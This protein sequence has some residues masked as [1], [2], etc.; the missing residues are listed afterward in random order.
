[1]DA[2]SPVPVCLS[3]L[4][5]TIKPQE[6]SRKKAGFRLSAAVLLAFTITITEY[7]RSCSSLG[8][9]TR[10][11]LIDLLSESNSSSLT[12]YSPTPEYFF[13]SAELDLNAV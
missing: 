11:F 8:Y 5:T 13:S 12:S 7:L 9:H 3:S 10:I 2:V 4:P 1:M 6:A